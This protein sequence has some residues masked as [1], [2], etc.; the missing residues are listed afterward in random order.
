TNPD[1]ASRVALTTRE[2]SGLTRTAVPAGT[3]TADNFDLDQPRPGM[4]AGAAGRPSRLAALSRHD[5]Q[6]KALRARRARETP[7][8]PGPQRG[9]NLPFT[10]DGVAGRAFRY[11]NFMRPA[12][13][14]RGLAEAN[15]HLAGA[16]ALDGDQVAGHGARKRARDGGDGGRPLDAVAV[17]RAPEP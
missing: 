1:K 4:I 5:G 3:P 17:E 15:P 14:S 6:L 11:G 16:G 13:G 12:G 7:A 2:G 9:D 8:A 10:I